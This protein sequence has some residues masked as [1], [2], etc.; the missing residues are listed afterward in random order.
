MAN[1]TTFKGTV[2]Q[3]KDG[4]YGYEFQLQ[5]KKEWYNFARDCDAPEP[6][7]GDSVEFEAWQSEKGRWYV[8]SLEIKRKDQNG[9]QPT[10]QSNDDRGAAIARSV[11]LKAAID[12][13]I[14]HQAFIDAP[15]EAKVTSVV[16]IAK[17]LEKKYLTP[18][19]SL[20]DRAAEPFE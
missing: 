10:Y 11:A 1:K 7:K 15:I 16:A 5:G 4:Q 6:D 19:E 9:S 8:D 13:L 2:F 17:Q 14:H 18:Q 20:E 3:G 12:V